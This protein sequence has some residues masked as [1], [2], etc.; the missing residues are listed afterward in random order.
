MRLIALAGIVTGLTF[1]AAGSAGGAVLYQQ[2]PAGSFTGGA[3][4]SHD[5]STDARD[6][7]AADDFAIGDGQVWTIQGVEVAGASGRQA[8]APRSA[9]VAIY[10]DAGGAPGTEVFTRSGLSAPECPA[11][12]SCDFR[13][14]PTGAPALAP[15]TY[16]ISLQTSGAQEWF[17]SQ[18]TADA[19]FGHPAVWRN[20]GD[21]FG[22]SCTTYRILAECG[23]SASDGQDLVFTLSG[24]VIDSRFSVLEMVARRLKLFARVNVVGAGTMRIGGKGVKKSAKRLGVG[25]HRLRVRLKPAVVYHLRS[26]RKARVRVK[27][28]YT[29]AGG[30]A[31]TERTKATLVPVGRG[32]YR[33][34]AGR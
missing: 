13:A 1:G 18:Y 27:L 20:P 32:A 19:T 23:G 10:A 29:A 21:A 30:D 7:Q 24:S 17:W 3:F 2:V 16:W 14:A 25:E 5:S 6:S 11:D 22:T 26:G 8:S 12:V 34:R 31:Y 9:A 33:V 28:T 4:L 15:G